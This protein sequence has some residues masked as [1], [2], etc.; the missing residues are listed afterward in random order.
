MKVAFFKRICSFTVTSSG[1]D[2]FI[3]MENGD[4]WVQGENVHCILG[5]GDSKSVEKPV[6]IT[7]LEGL[8][9]INVSHGEKHAV[10]L[11][12]DGN[13]YI[14]GNR[15]FQ[16]DAL[17]DETDLALSDDSDGASIAPSFTPLFIC[18]RKDMKAIKSGSFHTLALDKHGSVFGIGLNDFGQLGLGEDIKKFPNLTKIENLK[19]IMAISCGLNHSMALNQ[20]NELFVWG[21]NDIGQLGLGT[22]TNV[23]VP[24]KVAMNTQS[25]KM[26]SSGFN[27]NLVLTDDGKIYAFGCN[28]FGQCTGPADYYAIPRKITIVDGS[29]ESKRFSVVKFN[30]IAVCGNLSFAQCSKTGLFYVWGV[31][32]SGH[33]SYEPFKTESTNLVEVLAM[34]TQYTSFMVPIKSN[35]FALHS[36]VKIQTSIQS[37]FDNPEDG[38][39][40]FVFGD[41]NIYVQR[42]VLELASDYMNKMMNTKWAEVNQV[43]VTKYS[44]A[45]YYA[46]LYYLYFEVLERLDFDIAVQLYRLAI[47]FD[48]RKLYLKIMNQYRLRLSVENCFEYYKFA[49]VNCWDDYELIVA[50]FIKEHMEEVE[51]DDILFGL[52]S[53]VRK[54]AKIR[55][56]QLEKHRRSKSVG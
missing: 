21:K 23:T 13:L 4:L 15:S 30:F 33:G 18:S 51:I 31:P 22:V 12:N 6:S 14:W 52:P 34:Y 44:Y 47:E 43:T 17:E 20:C 45:T 32:S 24:T 26:I 53:H 46:Y 16:R 29:E 25:I 27:H 35:S 39:F 1:L 9:V 10:G 5:T 36:H 2:V 54:Q 50:D 55:L 37:G 48:D 19:G 38:D 28:M 41:K 56:E 3:V 40:K 7:K 11:T 42:Y 49:L 8:D